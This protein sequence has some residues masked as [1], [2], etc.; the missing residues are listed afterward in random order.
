MVKYHIIHGDTQKHHFTDEVLYFPSSSAE[1]SRVQLR[2]DISRATEWNVTFDFKNHMAYIRTHREPHL[3]L[4]LTGEHN[5]VK[6]VKKH[7]KGW[8]CAFSMV[9]DDHFIL[10]DVNKVQRMG[11]SVNVNNLVL[12]QD[13]AKYPTATKNEKWRI[14]PLYSP[15]LLQHFSHYYVE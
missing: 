4:H 14:E 11:T 7:G 12:T 8:P 5:V 3:V 1:N 15:Y 6:A 10:T 9:G 13:V 2:D